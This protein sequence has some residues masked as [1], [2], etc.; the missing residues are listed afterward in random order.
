M[1]SDVKQMH[2]GNDYPFACLSWETMLQKKD[3]ENEAV[4][5]ETMVK[6]LR[7]T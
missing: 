3:E 1:G 5:K 6:P 4:G 7:L 2:G